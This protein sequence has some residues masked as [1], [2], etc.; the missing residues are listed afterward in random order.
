MLEAVKRFGRDLRR[1]WPLTLLGIAAVTWGVIQVVPVGKK[2]TSL[3]LMALGA[4]GTFAPEIS[5]PDYWADTVDHAGSSL[6]V[7]LILGVRNNGTESAPPTKLELSLPSRY[8]M[9]RADGR[10][11]PGEYLTGTPMARYWLAEIGR[12]S[13]RER[14]EPTG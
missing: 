4:D 3:E 12:A 11:L 14:R 8:R 7:P 10:A 13:G 9:T 1:R 5:I 2:G 6:R